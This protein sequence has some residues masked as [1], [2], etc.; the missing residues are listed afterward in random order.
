MAQGV[1]DETDSGTASL[2]RLR[3]ATT[4]MGILVY[5]WSEAS[6]VGKSNSVN[7]KSIASDVLASKR[8]AGRGPMVK[9]L[10]PF[11]YILVC[12]LN[13]ESS[14]TSTDEEPEAPK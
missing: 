1:G 14:N 2:S 10:I 12:H 9:T 6:S 5:K 3:R 7:A 8:C 11:P 4:R 13:M